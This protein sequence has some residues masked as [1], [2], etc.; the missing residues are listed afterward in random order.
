[1][2]TETAA[3]AGQPAP[4]APDDGDYET[5][6]AALSASARGRAFLTEYTRRNRNADTEQLLAAIA[7][8]QQTVAANSAPKVTD[9][10][11]AELRALLDDIAVAQIELE[12]TIVATKATK[13][14]ELVA[15]VARRITAIMALAPIE[16]PPP[17]EATQPSLPQESRQEPK[18]ESKEA[19]ERTH[20]AVVPMPEQPELP[21]P[22]PLVTPLPSIALVRSETIMTE[23]TFVGPAPAVPNGE[24]ATIEPDVPKIEPVVSPP[25]PTVADTKRPK[26]AGPLASI[27]ALTEEERLALFT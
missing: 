6:C 15:L 16:S 17:A 10:I 14:A 12:A 9:T 24:P 26:P 19:V 5:F 20:L 13:L 22:S 27:M 3:R 11:K 8:L 18:A 7:Q 2:A 4:D 21:I 25:A 1:M 23:V